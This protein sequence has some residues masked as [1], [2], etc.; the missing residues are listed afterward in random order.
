[1]KRKIILSESEIQDIC[2]DIGTKLT[3]RLKDC[4]KPPV[5]LGVM[6]GAVPFMQDLIKRV[7]L[8]IV[9]D[10]IRLSS[11]DKNKSTGIVKVKYQF[12]VDLKD[13][14]LVI[15]EDV[16]DTG[17]SMKYLLDFINKNYEPKEVILVALFNKTIDR[18]EEVEVDYFGKELK[19]NDFLMGYGLDY[20]EFDRNVPYVYSA[21]PDD[22]KFWD[23]LNK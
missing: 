11:Y 13:R 15:V 19:S 10:Y 12:D 20:C 22:V 9:T 17:I 1:M 6:K 14:T 23:S 8:T 18:K 5:F 7:D 2:K 21:S 16:V 3:K 4:D